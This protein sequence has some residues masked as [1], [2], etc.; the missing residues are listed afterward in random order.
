MNLREE[1]NDRGYVI[2]PRL[3]GPEVV[4][5]LLEALGVI[6][7]EE[8]VRA[9]DQRVYAVRNLMDVVPADPRGMVSG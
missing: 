5:S 1:L 7:P 6:D 9:R 3:V 8:S 2:V 4:T